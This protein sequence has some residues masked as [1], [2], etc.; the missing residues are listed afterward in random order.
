[1]RVVKSVLFRTQPLL[2]PRGRFFWVLGE[3]TVYCHPQSDELLA[4]VGV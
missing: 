3:G 2:T 1:M 4:W